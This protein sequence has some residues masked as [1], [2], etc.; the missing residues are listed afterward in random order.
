MMFLHTKPCSSARLCMVNV[1]TMGG[2]RSRH[3]CGPGLVRETNNGPRS[4]GYQAMGYP[5]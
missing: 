1:K 2:R 5:N 3:W 4:E